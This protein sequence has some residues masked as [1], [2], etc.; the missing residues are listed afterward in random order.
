MAK[1]K[2]QKKAPKKPTGAAVPY[3]PLASPYATVGDFNTAV[4]KTARSQI[5]PQLGEI[6]YQTGQAT[7]AHQNRNREQQG[8]YQ[9]ESDAAR[10]GASGLAQSNQAILDSLKAGGQDVQAGM[11]AA[12]RA[13]QQASEAEASRLGGQA[14][15]VD[16]NLLTAMAGYGGAG[17]MALAGDISGSNARANAQI[18]ITGTAGRQ[19]GEAES[20]RFEGIRQGLNDQ[21]RGIF[22][23]L[24]GLMEQARQNLG[25][26][27]LARSGQSFQQGLARDQFGL[28]ER[29]QSDSELNSKRTRISSRAQDQLAQDTFGEQK[30]A[31]RV[32]EAQKTI[33]LGI[34]QQNADTQRKQVEAA[35]GSDKD[36]AEAKGKQFDAGVQILQGVLGQ[37]KNDIVYKKDKV[38]GSATKEIDVK[39]TMQRIEARTKGKFDQTLQS[40]QAAT[41]MGEGTALRVMMAGSNTG[42]A[43]EAAARLNRLK[44]ARKA[45]DNSKNSGA[46]THPNE[47]QHAPI[48]P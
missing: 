6:D 28:A 19:A 27:E 40:I 44:K 24:P 16:P 35:A 7:S 26:T 4:Q 31:Q 17:N 23:T 21:R 1:K 45:I 10:A 32:S 9:A 2:P 38:T 47:G 15:T 42:W 22:A 25:N 39:K 13:Q 20:R 46:G 14:R 11:A 34:S 36:V 43:K 41:G 48:M 37:T 33:E 5:D 8:W 30:R 18:G 29:A 3:N 12:L